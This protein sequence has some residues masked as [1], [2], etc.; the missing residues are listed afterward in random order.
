MTDTGTRLP[1]TRV[2][3]YTSGVGY[4]E[5]TGEVEGT[6]SLTLSFPL[7]QVN[8]V[9]KSLVLLDGGDGALQPVTYAAQDPVGRAL[10]A[11]SVDVGDSPDRATLLDRMRGARVTVT[12]DDPEPVSGLILSVESQTVSL[13]DDRTTESQTLNLLAEDGLHAIPLGFIRRLKIED[14]ALDDELRQALAAVAQGR[15]A[16]KRPVTLTFSGPGRRPVQVGYLAEAP[17]W[18]TTYRLVLGDSPLMQGWA[19]VQNT[20]QEDWTEAQLSLISGRPISFIQDLYT[21]LY[22]HRPTVQT[23]ILS[24]PTPQA[25]AGG[26][27][28][29]EPVF[30]SMDQMAAAPAGMPYPPAP[31]MA[32]PMASGVANVRQRKAAG[33]ADMDVRQAAKQSVATSGAQMGAALF[34]YHIDVPVSVPRQQSAMIPFVAGPVEAERVSVFNARVQSDHPLSGARLKNVTGLHLMGG[35]LTVFDTPE[36]GGAAGYVG[37]ALIDDT[38][39]GQTRLLTYAIDLAVDADALDRGVRTHTTAVTLTPGLLQIQQTQRVETQYTLKNHAAV[40]RLVIVEHPQRGTDWVLTEPAQPSERT[41]DALRFERT[42]APGASETLA[43]HEE[44]PSTQRL[45]LLSTSPDDLTLYI[46]GGPAGEAV[47]AALRE[48]VTRRARMTELEARIEVLENELESISGG[49][50]RIRQNMKALDPKIDL[51]RRYV[52]ELTTQENRIAALT[53]E[54]RALSDTLA[55]AEAALRDYVNGL[56]LG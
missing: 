49:Q 7:G 13:S 6:A 35:P 54:R 10:Q 11:F 16:N 36:A 15:D 50:E 32:A 48:I 33:P 21:P 18:Q 24:S 29:N 41:A 22:V 55:Q 40:P 20:G 14:P 53:N 25:Y 51:Y 5:R 1:I 44:R 23:R 34:A 56:T 43:V 38:E 28:M 27:G 19:L 37:D 3:L 26:G 45:S 42:V 12:T 39:P 17:A 4:F 2:T 46:N 9:L 30:G 31:V 52:G 47:K 8:D